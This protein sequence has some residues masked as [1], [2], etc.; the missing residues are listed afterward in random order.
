MSSVLI[1][2]RVPIPLKEHL[3]ADCERN[4]T[5]ISEVVRVIIHEYYGAN[6][7]KEEIEKSSKHFVNSDD[8][9]S[10]FKWLVEKRVY[11]T[12][13]SSRSTLIDLKATLL[14]INENEQFPIYIQKEFS[15]VQNE[16]SFAIMNLSEKGSYFSFGQPT[17]NNPFNYSLV[18]DF[19]LT[20]DLRNTFFI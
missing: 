7:N 8:F 3:D 20:H 2:V 19:I 17:S 14:N 5:T 6:E 10:L 13:F 1:N 18:I 4:N 9:K 11:P 16:I 15:K 12:D